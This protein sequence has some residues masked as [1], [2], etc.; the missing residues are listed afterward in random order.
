ML[1]QDTLRPVIIAMSLYILVPRFV[2]T[3]SGIEFIDDI[4]MTLIAQKD[5]MMSGTI[6][7]GL[8]VF[9]TNYIQDKFF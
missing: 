7:V 8:I 2:T 3:P 9:A 5:S 4:V 6:I 1:D